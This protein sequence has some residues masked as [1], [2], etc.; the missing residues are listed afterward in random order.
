MIISVSANTASTTTKL[1]K[2][3]ISTASTTTKLIK[4]IT[5]IASTITKLIK[6]TSHS[7]LIDD[8][9]R[10]IYKYYKSNPTAT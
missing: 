9:R 4:T 7:L 2:T 1:I 10:Y 6:T 3:T 8:K 5:S